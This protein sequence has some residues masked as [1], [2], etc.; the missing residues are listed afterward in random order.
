MQTKRIIFGQVREIPKSVE[1]SRIIPFV[2]STDKRD[3]HHTVLNQRNWQLDN[4]RKN[5]VVGYMHNLYGDMCNPPDPDDVIAIDK[6]VALESLQG[7]PALIGYPQFEPASLNLKADKIFRK[8]VLGTLRGVSVGFLDNGKGKWGIGNEAEGRENETYYFDAQELIEYSIVNIPSNADGVKRMNESLRNQTHA[9]IMYAFRA[10]GKNYRL[11]QIE[12]M[13]ICDVLAL[14][15]G[16]DLGIKE[17]NPEKVKK[18]INEPQ[19][20]L[21]VDSIIE[22]QQIELKKSIIE[23]HQRHIKSIGYN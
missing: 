3:R 14:L 17:T 4:Y 1:E 18:M 6:G 2:L 10:L 12:N 16:K 7:K 19:A 9:A 11:S 5:P 23:N 22:A 15:D 21:D 8:I 20:R 13:R